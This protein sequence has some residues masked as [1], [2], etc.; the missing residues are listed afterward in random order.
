MAP[1]RFQAHDR[2]HA[3]SQLGVGVARQRAPGPDQAAGLVDE[4]GYLDDAIE[5]AKKKAGVTEARVVTYKRPGEYS[6]NM[7]SKLLGPSPLA[8]LI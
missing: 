1:Q 8:G 4:V 6:N 2:R 3:Q 7:Y 5:L